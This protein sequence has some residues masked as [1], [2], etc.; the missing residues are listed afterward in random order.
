MQ[1]NAL[2]HAAAETIAE[3]KARGIKVLE[4][5]PFLPDLN[6]IET[7]WDKIKDYVEMH[8]LEDQSHDRLRAA[9]KGSLGG[10]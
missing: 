1:D 8:F 5:S 7:V 2:A 4:W 6:P 10:Y 3:P 9:V